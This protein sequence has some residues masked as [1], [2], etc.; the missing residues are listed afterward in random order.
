[1]KKS[2]AYKKAC[3]F[4]FLYCLF[5]RLNIYSSFFFFFFFFFFFSIKRTNFPMDFPF[6]ICSKKIQTNG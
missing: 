4:S 6:G 5:L 1:M 3:I 2:V